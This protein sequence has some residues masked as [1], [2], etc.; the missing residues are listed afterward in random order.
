MSDQGQLPW[1]E[2]QW[3][4]VQQLVRETAR[5]S[6]VASAIFPLVGPL[7]PGHVRVPHLRLTPAGGAGVL[8]WLPDG[9]TE[10]LE[11]DDASTLQLTTVAVDV[12]LKT[13]QAEEAELA[14]ARS[15]LA[16]AADIVAR[17]EDAIAF[18]GLTA[19]VGGP[20]SI[21]NAPAVTPPIYT[22]SNQDQKGL[23]EVN[24]HPALGM[25][26]PAPFD[27]E[28]LVEKIIRAVGLLEG[29]GQYGPFACVLGSELY[30]AAV[31]PSNSLVLPLDRILP[32][33]N[34]PLL[35]S[36]TLPP[37][38]GIVVAG[39]GAPID[40]VVGSDIHVRFVQMSVEPSYVLRVSERFVLRIKQRDAIVRIEGP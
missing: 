15:M 33:L 35:R 16:R 25:T 34:G 39:A 30:S 14:A 8:K 4:S 23:L 22:V 1:T 10:R 6:S 27:G 2:E 5:K 31:T 12:Y 7:P 32:F 40:L 28:E 11:I 24:E 38:K 36:G 13:T 37:H 20:P 3:A 29:A 17:L 9:P 26:G 21:K 19:V 18:N